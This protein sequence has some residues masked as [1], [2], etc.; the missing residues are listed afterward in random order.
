MRAFFEEYGGVIII[1]AVIV[2]MI[3]LVTI[4]MAADGPVQKAFINMINTL[5]N[6]A[7]A[8]NVTAA[9]TAGLW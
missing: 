5:L 1:G 2:A 6:K 8:P 7:G 4:L 9:L 3:T